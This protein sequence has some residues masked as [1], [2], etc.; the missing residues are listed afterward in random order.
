MSDCLITLDK[1]P[2]I[3]PAGA[4]ETWRQ[5]FSRIVLKVTQPKATS[6]CQ[7]DQIQ[8]VLK[9]VIDGAVHWVQDIWGTKS[10]TED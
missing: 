1:Q 8:A 2:G 10:T 6:M 5:F 7:D 4:G 9:A 3:R